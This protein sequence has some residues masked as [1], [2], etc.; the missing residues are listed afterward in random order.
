M[1]WG[2][3]SGI[4]H[5]SPWNIPLYQRSSLKFSWAENGCWTWSCMSLLQVNIKS[6]FVRL[7]VVVSSREHGRLKKESALLQLKTAWNKERSLHRRLSL[8]T[9]KRFINGA[10]QHWVSCWIL[11]VLSSAV[12][13]IWMKSSK[14]YFVHNTKLQKMETQSVCIQLRLSNTVVVCL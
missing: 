6:S 1:E 9:G 2:V 4:Y 10:S 14:V 7:I 13:A 5:G 11:S 8:S 12:H 3:R